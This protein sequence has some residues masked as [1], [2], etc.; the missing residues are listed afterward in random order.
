MYISLIVS[1]IKPHLSPWFL[2]ACAAAIIYRNN[3]F[4]LYQQN[5][6]ESKV[7][8]RHTA[9]HYKRV[10]EAKL[11][12]A[13]KTKE[14]ITSQKVRLPRKFALRT[15]GKLPIVFSTKINLLY[16]PYS[17]VWRCCLLHLIKQNF[18]AETFLWTL[19]LI[20]QISLYLFSFLETISDYVIFL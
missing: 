14:F 9:N 7:K 18:L 10:L 11:A 5:K 17:I 13:N 15:F 6:S 12:Y 8:F 4:C 2:A 19:T 20:T 3:I 16:L 1:I